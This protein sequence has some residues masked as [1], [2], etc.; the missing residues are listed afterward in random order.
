MKNTRREL[1]RHAGCGLL[2]RA[3][4]MSGFD[5][6]SMVAAVPS[7]GADYRALVCIFLFGGNDGNN[8]VVSL[9]R[10][11]EYASARGMLAIPE[12]QLLPVLPNKHAG[13]FGLHPSMGSLQTLFQQ[14]KVAVVCNVGTLTAPITKA[15]YQAGVRPY[16]LFSHS[17]QQSQ[18]QTSATAGKVGSGW[19]G[20][21]ADATQDAATGFPTVTSLA[22]VPIFTI[23]G[24]TR[25]LS[26][27]SAPTPLNQTLR[28]V[29]PDDALRHILEIE[30]SAS[31]PT[32][33]KGAAAVQTQSLDNSALLST[34]PT[35]ATAFPNTSIANQLKQ[36]A[37][38]IS[39]SSRLGL[40]RQ[41]FFCSLG[42]FDTHTGQ[43]TAQ[44]N[45]LGQ[46]STAMSSFYDTT[47]ELGVSSNVTTFTLSDFGRTYKSAGTA[48]GTV[49][50]DH[51]WGAHHFIM[52]GAVMGG[53]FYGTFPD[54]T[55]G[56]PMD[57]DSGASA[58]GR[59]IP[60]VSVD[61]YAATL[62]SWYGLPASDLPT[63]F[64]NIGRFATANLGFM[65]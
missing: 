15:N 45:L 5:R 39:V 19:G 7:A 23:G 16:Q 9:D 11:S 13:R 56:G 38:V 34:D 35:I 62:A 47:V 32:L 28:V 26:I 4:F 36:V 54:V 65:L 29:Q 1:L 30:K 53:D 8:T 46:L 14:N 27:G 6:L 59:W 60:S 48:T 31:M 61:Q 51:A 18:W 37:K 64:P 33:V 10:Y 49:G 57:V 12:A 43:I 21:M 20:R 3:A 52:G 25:P 55:P 42:G 17:D 63:V 41:I 24:R 50:S 2:G 44:S 40:R 22:G 58:R